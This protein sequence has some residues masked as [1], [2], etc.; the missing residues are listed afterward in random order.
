M[1]PKVSLTILALVLL[2][3]ALFGAVRLYD[4]ATT[5]RDGWDIFSRVDTTTDM[6]TV[7]PQ[8]LVSRE[9]R[10]AIEHVVYETRGFGIPWSIW[11]VSREEL[12]TTLP[13]DQ[14]AEQQFAE[15]PVESTEGAGDGLLMAVIVPESDHTQTEV[16]F[17]TG[18]N[19]YPKGGITP[20]RL[21]YIANVQMRILLDEDRLGDAIIE[22]ATWVEWT[23]LFEP[24]PDPPPTN[25]ERGLQELLSPL[26]AAGIVGL[27]AIVAGAALVSWWITWRGTG[28]NAQVIL[29]GATAA[30]VARGRVDDAVISGVVMDALD[31]GALHVDDRGHISHT[32]GQADVRWDSLLRSTIDAIIARGNEPTLARLAHA[33]KAAGTLRHRIEDELANLG[34]YYPRS[35]I[36]TLRVRWIAAAGTILGLIGFVIS[37]VGE[38][39][40]AL[41]ASVALTVV[42]LV[43]LIWN[44][45]RSWSTRHG[46]RAVRSWLDHHDRH[47]DRER[48][49]YEAIVTFETIELLPPQ[50]SPLRPDALPLIAAIDR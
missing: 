23:Q 2:A 3:A 46:R 20:E 36:H 50:R 48:A 1:P 30:A 47:T 19:F 38:S 27:T 10:E 22:G 40:P 5:E 21:D 6:L 41:G 32:G 29:N 4:V 9:D 45:R 33:L 39:G 49:L 44:E 34:L 26:G 24:T 28:R 42:S 14:I 31:R 43:V 35:P 12:D 37:V 18:P 7:V 25:L 17:V 15:N 16:A 11:V 13:A 8:S